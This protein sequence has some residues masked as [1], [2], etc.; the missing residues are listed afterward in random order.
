MPHSPMQSAFAILFLKEIKNHNTRGKG[1]EKEREMRLGRGQGEGKP[2]GIRRENC[3]S[4]ERRAK[5]K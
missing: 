5:V 3:W 2:N 4:L 1:R